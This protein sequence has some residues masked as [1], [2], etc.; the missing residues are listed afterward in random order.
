MGAAGLVVSITRGG[1]VY[2]IAPAPRTAADVL[3]S[4]EEKTMPAPKATGKWLTASVVDDAAW[5]SPASPDTSALL[6]QA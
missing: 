3:A 2:D 1:A 6:S 5:T 4:S